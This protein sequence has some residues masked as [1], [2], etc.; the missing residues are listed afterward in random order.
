LKYSWVIEG[1]SDFVAQFSRF[2]PT[3][4]EQVAERFEQAIPNTVMTFSCAARIVRHRHFRNGEAFEL[5]QCWKE[6]MRAVEEFYVG[7]AFVRDHNLKIQTERIN[8][9]VNRRKQRAK[10]FRF[11]VTGNDNAQFRR[12]HLLPKN[13]RTASQT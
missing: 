10:V 1:L 3:N 12:R 13:S 4:R 9:C 8:S 5:D 6:T 2:H 11:V 7:D